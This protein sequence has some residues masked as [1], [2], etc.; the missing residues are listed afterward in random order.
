M[1]V[2][3]KSDA[4]SRVGVGEKILITSE[5]TIEDIMKFHKEGWSIY[6]D[7]TQENFINLNT[8]DFQK[9]PKSLMTYYMVAMK[10]YFG[11]LSDL[12]KTIAEAGTARAEFGYDLRT[13]DPK[14][15]LEIRNVPDGMTAKWERAYDDSVRTAKR[16]GYVLARGNDIST[17]NNDG[18]KPGGHYVGSEDKPEMVAMLI[19]K[20]NAKRNSDRIKKKANKIKEAAKTNF[21]DSVKQTGLKGAMAEVEGN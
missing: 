19:S 16:K 6:F 8:E 9:L 13:A 2:E 1:K 15:Q 4:V 10:E 3:K 12:T 14:D 18:S 7:G 5:H 17:F 21:R 11:K 20:E